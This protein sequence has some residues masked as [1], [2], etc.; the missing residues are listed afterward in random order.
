MDG[1]ASETDA[2]AERMT[3][4]M[5]WEKERQADTFAASRRTAAPT[6]APAPGG[7]ACRLRP[8]LPPWAQKH[9]ALVA[10]ATGPPP[11]IF[12]AAVLAGSDLHRCS[13]SGRA[14]EHRMLSSSSSN[15]S[16]SSSSSSSACPPISCGAGSCS[17][18][19]T[20]TSCLSAP[21]SSANNTFSADGLRGAGDAFSGL[22]GDGDGDGEPAISSATA[23]RASLVGE[24][25]GTGA[26]A[27]AGN[28]D[29]SGDVRFCGADRQRIRRSAFLGGVVVADDTS[30]A[31][32]SSLS[33]SSSCLSPSP[34]IP[35]FSPSSL[36]IDPKTPTPTT[37]S[38][39][40]STS[41]PS[42]WLPLL[43]SAGLGRG[44]DGHVPAAEHPGRPSCP[45]HLR[46]R[47]F[48]PPLP[49]VELEQPAAQKRLLEAPAVPLGAALL[50]R[51][52][53]LLPFLPLA[54]PHLANA[55][56]LGRRRL[57]VRRAAPAAGHEHGR[58]G[59]RAAGPPAPAA[60]AEQQPR[61][62]RRRRRRQL[63]LLRAARAR[64]RRLHGPPHSRAQLDGGGGW[65]TWKRW[66]AARAY[67]G[68]QRI[69]ELSSLRWER[70]ACDSVGVRVRLRIRLPASLVDLRPGP[71]DHG[72]SYCW[73]L[74]AHVMG[75]FTCVLF[76]ILK[77][78]K[79]KIITL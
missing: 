73:F 27:A 74:V 7:G 6:G 53:R 47:R 42:P 43:G 78:C 58:R 76:V 56:H 35:I 71:L 55:R 18:A 72:T 5:A 34:L 20:A 12:A 25:D 29:V 32:R 16:S 4:M 44:G 62:P 63:R 49:G 64:G 22:R 17:C 59:R 40:S 15:S 11:A 75:E 21:S 77:L 52:R 51:G 70:Q 23:A 33:S 14:D 46:R 50:R 30:C 1:W 69:N 26:G 67:T 8:L 60:L 79:F 57:P 24:G 28:R 36:P 31:S 66:D 61:Q 2:D 19:A 13:T 38:S 37:I 65:L 54:H 39:S 68:R 10:S 41:C 45:L 9:P 48:L 3:M